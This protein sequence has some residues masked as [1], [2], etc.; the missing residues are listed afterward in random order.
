MTAEPPS[1]PTPRP[2]LCEHVQLDNG[3]HKLVLNRA[4]RPAIEE[5]GEYV[6]HILEGSPAN[7]P[8]VR[9]LFDSRVGVLPMGYVSGKVRDLRERFRDPA[10]IRYASL[11]PNAAIGG[12]VNAI[13]DA[14]RLPRARIRVFQS[15]QE[16]EAIA[17]LLSDN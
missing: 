15:N 14:L 9:I 10:P 4:S 3:I 2:R 1:S 16:A 11:V 7:G 5:W 8:T 13:A 17:W 12:L 6:A